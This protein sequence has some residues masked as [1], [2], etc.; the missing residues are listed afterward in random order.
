MILT[1]LTRAAA[2]TA[3]SFAVTAAIAEVPAEAGTVLA[4]V[5][6]TEITL[7]H[8]VALRSRLPAQYQQLPDEVLLE[9]IL[10][11]LIQQTALAQAIEDDIDMRMA[12]SME[13]D[14]RAY[15]ATQMI[16]RISEQEVSEEEI[17]Q[18]YVEALDGFV[19]DPEYS[20]S[21]ILLE[22]EDEALEVVRLLEDG[23]DF[24]ELARER[25]TGP[26]G[27][28]G[29]ALGWFSEGMMV[30][31]FEEAVM[32][33]AVGEIAGPVQTQFGWHVI[34]LADMR[35]G[36]PPALEEVRPEIAMQLQRA[37]VEQALG[38]LVEAAEIERL[39][40]GIDPAAI[41]DGGVFDR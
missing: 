19:P 18:A 26:S 33:M 10:E 14:R 39:E 27:P 40:T 31:P 36:E 7:G 38:G 21:H 4:R 13:N 17:V 9:G 2:V 1:R 12:L 5:N 16:E 6:G 35:V 30:A 20:A 29:G 37:R 32:A 23:A 28:D 3:L 34:L 25:S 15:L 41:R 22:T 8:V 24:A 11:Q